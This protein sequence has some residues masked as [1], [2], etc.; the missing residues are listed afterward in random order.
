[1]SAIGA[2][3]YRH[4][5]R[6]A[7]YAVHA[8]NGE[9]WDCLV[10]GN[11]SAAEADELLGTSAEATPPYMPPVAEWS[12]PTVTFAA[13]V[14]TKGEAQEPLITCEQGTLLPP[15]GLALLASK[16]GDGKT[17]W[18]VECVLHASAGRD[19][20]GL[21]FPRPLN[22]LV[23]ENEGPREAF[24][25][26]LDA[27]LAT[28]EHGGAPRIWDEANA[29]GAVRVSDRTVRERM[30]AVVE[31]HAIDLIV[32]DTLTRFG[33]RGNGTPEE[34]RD[35]V[36]LLTELGLG[37]DVAFLL[38][39]HQRTRPDPGEDEL[40]RIAGAW[41][42][43]ADLI[44]LLKRL[45]GDRAR[46]S[47]PKTRWTDGERP[48]SILAFDPAAASF[49]HVADDVPAERDLVAELAELMA[50]GEWWTVTALRKSKEE[51]G[52]GAGP[53]A[54]KQALDSDRFDSVN[55]AAIGKRVDATYYRLQASR[56]PYDGRDASPSQ[57][58]SE[59][60]ASPVFSR[61]GETLRD[62]ASSR[63]GEPSR[64]A[65]TVA[66]ET[67]PSGEMCRRCGSTFRRG[68]G[69]KSDLCGDCVR[70]DLSPEGSTT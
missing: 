29:W 38:L 50:D 58:S 6:C 63:P 10:C 61:K 41:P 70:R 69:N 40:E 56:G 49:V 12:D 33:A 51:G 34:T 52:V 19:Y 18:T 14:A 3:E 21:S 27:R 22:V 24:R 47:F 15:G 30:R 13:F 20:V 9:G 35:F 11:G 2:N 53:D 57:A 45:G 64:E 68:T 48:A 43:H 54:V 37:R 4:C 67:L 26:K 1:V 32:S 66:P 62:D 25:R 44:L 55:G 59:H 7:T 65:V 31:A 23:V 36:E 16:T 5:S 42:P 17:T 28:W 46:L 39:H 60:E 8:F